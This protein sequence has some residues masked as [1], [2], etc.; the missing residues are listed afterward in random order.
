MAPHIIKVEPYWNV[1][2]IYITQ[3]IC[4]ETI[5]VEPYWN[6]KFDNW[7]MLLE[8]YDIKVEPYW[9][10]KGFFPAWLFCFVYN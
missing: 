3:F 9:N 8:T 5:K 7:R 6:V 1:K 2:R 10:V 4:L